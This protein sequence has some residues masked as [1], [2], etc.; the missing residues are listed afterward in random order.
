MQ[1]VKTLL[2]KNPNL[3]KV[4]SFHPERNEKRSRYKKVIKADYDKLYELAKE[5]ISWGR[6]IPS[7]RVDWAIEKIFNFGKGM[8]KEYHLDLL[9]IDRLFNQV[10]PHY[11]RG[12]L[13][14]CLI[15]GLYTDIIKED[16]TLRLYL[17]RYPATVSGLGYRHHKGK[18]EI[19]GNRAYYLGVEME[20]GQIL[21]RGNVGNYLG[22]SIKGG[23]IMVEGNARNW[24]GERMKGGLIFIRGDAGHIVGKKM[25]GGEIVVEGDVGYWVGD[26]MRGGVI[27]IKG[28]YQSLGGER[29]GGEI[30]ILGNKW[31]RIG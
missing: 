24:V 21:V 12:G 1:G 13:L 20:H 16:D 7:W 23:Q 6:G 30:Y 19:I 22:K 29:R 8:A 27:R 17:K 14:G 28:R 3:L 31:E 26:D 18:L 4:E 25:T 11:M 9:E 10:L 2:E 15:S 5:Y